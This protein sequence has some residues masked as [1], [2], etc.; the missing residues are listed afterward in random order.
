MEVKE[1]YAEVK[2]DASPPRLKEAMNQAYTAS[3][4]SFL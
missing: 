4:A 2:A 3:A 1:T